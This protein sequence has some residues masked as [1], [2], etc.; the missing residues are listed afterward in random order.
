MAFEGYYRQVPLKMEAYDEIRLALADARF[1]FG[2]E[3]RTRMAS[4]REAAVMVVNYDNPFEGAP[5]KS[6]AEADEIEIHHQTLYK[7]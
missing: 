4:A 6:E 5:E 7:S 2:A 1:L 3:V